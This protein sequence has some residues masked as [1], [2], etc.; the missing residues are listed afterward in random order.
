ML[1]RSD[2]NLVAWSTQRFEKS[3]LV[4]YLAP[5]VALLILGASASARLAANGRS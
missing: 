2:G 3:S 4:E 5:Q 1:G